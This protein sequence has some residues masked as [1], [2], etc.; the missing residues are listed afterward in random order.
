VKPG[1]LRD[2]SPPRRQAYNA[3]RLLAQRTAAQARARIPRES[4][5]TRPLLFTQFVCDLLRPTFPLR[6][7][8][9][10]VRDRGQHQARVPAL[11]WCSLAGACVPAKT[12]QDASAW[13]T[14]IPIWR[15]AASHPH[16][17]RVPRSRHGTPAMYAH[18]EAPPAR[19]I[20]D[21]GH[22]VHPLPV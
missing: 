19:R 12:T 5:R 13:S 1:F 22:A 7:W 17:R 10:V 15:R 21:C 9:A 4:S 11:T 8:T 16:A 18:T 14:V 3:T 6:L 20:V 2:P